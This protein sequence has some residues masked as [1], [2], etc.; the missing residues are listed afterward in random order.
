MGSSREIFWT[1]YW[2]RAERIRLEIGLFYCPLPK[3]KRRKEKTVIKIGR[4][5]SSTKNGQSSVLNLQYK[6]LWH[7]LWTRRFKTV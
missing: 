2:S 4:L 3:R 5:K 7:Q 6:E 1:F